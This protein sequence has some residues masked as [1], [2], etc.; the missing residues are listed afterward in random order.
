MAKPPCAPAQSMLAYRI[1]TRPS[2][3][4]ISIF[5]TVDLL[6]LWR[7]ESNQKTVAFS[8]S[9]ASLA[10][11]VGHVTIHSQSKLQ[12]FHVQARPVTPMASEPIFQVEKPQAFPL[13]PNVLG[14]LFRNPEPPNSLG[15]AGPTSKS[16]SKLRLHFRLRALVAP[17]SQ[18]ARNPWAFCNGAKV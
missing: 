12:S 8:D 9:F 5:S 6:S 15:P 10:S 4:R 13:K 18:P 17:A 3:V 11:P 2:K 7:L 1:L 16:K 14:G